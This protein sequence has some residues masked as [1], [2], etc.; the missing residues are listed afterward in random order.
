MQNSLSLN[1][2]FIL[3]KIP[4]ES[5]LSFDL[6][7][8]DIVLAIAVIVLLLLFISQRQGRPA[9]SDS[10]KGHRTLLAK[11]GRTAIVTQNR[12]SGTFSSDSVRCAHHLGYLRDH[13]SNT[14]IPD[15]CFGCQDVMRC[16][17]FDGSG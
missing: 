16:L 9:E 8:I 13:P 1:P 4:V 17:S 7:V 10:I 5:M 6:S 11:G 12:E 3:K 14:P 15:E 2:G